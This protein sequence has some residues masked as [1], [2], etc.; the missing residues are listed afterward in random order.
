MIAK[1]K[2]LLNLDTK[3]FVVIM[4]IQG[5]GKSTIV[6]E[7]EKV[8][9]KVVCPDRIRIELA[10]KQY[11]EDKLEG[12]LVGV[13]QNFESQV[14]ALAQARVNSYLKAGDSVIFDATNTTV[15]ARKRLL[16]WGK[17][18]HMPVIAIYV[19]CPLEIA[20]QRN[21][22][23]GTTITGTDKDGNLVY[24]RSVPDFVIKNKWQT[25][26]LPTCQEGFTEVYI[27]HVG[28]GETKNNDW[29]KEIFYNM[30]RSQDLLAHLSN[31][32]EHGILKDLIPSFDACWGLD[33]ENKYHNL[34]LHEHMIKAADY[35]K[36]ENLAL[37]VATL[38]HD[39]GKLPTKKKYGKTKF[40][41]LQFK[42]GEKVEVLPLEQEG[43]I[44]AYKLDYQGEVSELMTIKHVELDPN[45]HYYGHELVGS[46]MARRL[47]KELGFDDEFADLIY[48]YVL[49]HM[50]L[51]YQTFSEKSMEKLINKVGKPIVRMMVKLKK[52]DKS[53]SASNDINQYLENFQKIEDMLN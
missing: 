12:E 7:F 34:P 50:D 27:L 36:G 31:L 53:A 29:A 51:P 28:L 11:G 10:Q 33:Q 44:K 3:R 47:V 25:Q 40:N 35:V 4:G 42:I 14:W 22:T 46:I 15:K 49:Y 9:Y 37:F 17:Q 13:L 43:F 16:S 32:H 20:L 41:S 1:I 48:Q 38:I 24:G 21:E 2:H 5:S 6:T 18:N 8:G 52:A 45:A 39:I 23:R 26:I 19:E 30:M